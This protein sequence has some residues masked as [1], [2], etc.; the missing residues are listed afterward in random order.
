MNKSLVIGGLSLLQAGPSRAVKLTRSYDIIICALSWEK[1]AT[2][3]LGAAENLSGDL[4]LLKF[5]SLT[6]DIEQ[7]KRESL[8]R[9]EAVRVVK[10]TVDLESS[11]SYRSNIATLTEFVEAEVSSRKRPLRI[12]LDMTCIPKSYSLFL[13]GLCFNRSYVAYVDILYSEGAYLADDPAVDSAPGQ[14]GRGIVSDGEWT[15]LQIP[16][17]GADVAIP[18]SRDVIVALGGEVGLSLPFIEKYEPRKLQV[19]LI[20]ESLVQTPD[21]LLPSERAALAE[22]L[23][24]PNAHRLNVSLCDV[25]GLVEQATRTSRS[26]DAD[27]VSALALGSKPHALAMGLAAMGESNVEVICRIPKRYKPLDVPPTGDVWL[28]SI[29][30]RFEPD[31]YLDIPA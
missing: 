12:L 9:F 21:R 15:S 27:V 5:A 10:K 23:A 13:I 26:S 20:S 6:E 14:P 30:D 16:Y 31:A 3:A 7:A 4:V 11:V 28:Y 25:V 29:D 8:T 19:V 22:L 18:S 17:L 1:R 24:E 2:T